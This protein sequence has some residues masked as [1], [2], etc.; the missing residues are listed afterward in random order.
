MTQLSGRRAGIGTVR[1]P[2]LPSPTVQ[3]LLGGSTQGRQWGPPVSAVSGQPSAVSFQLPGGWLRTGLR[4]LLWREDRRALPPEGRLEV[5]R[6]SDPRARPGRSG[7][8]PSASASGAL[9]RHR[10][11]GAAVRR[12][13]RRSPGA[14]PR[15][16]A[17]SKPLTRLYSR[18]AGR[19]STESSSSESLMAPASLVTLAHLVS[20]LR[21]SISPGRASGG[22]GYARAERNRRSVS[23]E[24]SAPTCPSRVSTSSSSLRGG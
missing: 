7:G 1:G 11:A 24:G 6:P 3:G 4:P 16:A 15:T 17:R 18:L 23:L 14:Q 10:R 5:G 13:G 20:M 21:R 12:V 22:S 19:S 9:A 2:I 8:R